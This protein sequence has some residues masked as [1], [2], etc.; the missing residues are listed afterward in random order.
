MKVQPEVASVPLVYTDVFEEGPDSWVHWERIILRRMAWD[1][2][3]KVWDWW[4]SRNRVMLRQTREM[5]HATSRSS[6]SNASKP[7][8]TNSKPKC[9]NRRSSCSAFHFTAV[10]E[11]TVQFRSIRQSRVTQPPKLTKCH[12]CHT[13]HWG[14]DEFASGNVT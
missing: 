7:L 12:A 14:A 2:I 13:F 11:P 9:K 1:S 10:T 8:R 5:R 6:W 3:G 4:V